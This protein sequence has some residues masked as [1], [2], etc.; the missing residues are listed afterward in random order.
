MSLWKTKY[1]GCNLVLDVFVNS[2]EQINFGIVAI[3]FN[4]VY[5]DGDSVPVCADV[6]T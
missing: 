1:S 2:R 6:M 4:V 3:I 5:F